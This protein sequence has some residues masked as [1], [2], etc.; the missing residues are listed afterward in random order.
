M[1][2]QY[3]FQKILDLK[4]DE[5]D[6]KEQEYSRSV[7]Q[8]EKV[9]TAL[10]QLLMQKEEIEAFY[11]ERIETGIKI[12]EIQHNE[13][14]L[15]QLQE[16]IYSEQNRA[17]IA[18]EKMLHKEK[19]MQAASVE[20]KKFEKLKEWKKEEHAKQLKKAEEQQLDEIT[21]RKYAFR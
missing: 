6:I 13:A 4:K 19:E 1:S 2:F 7:V 5:K 3:S 8:F 12:Q 10:Y 20:W 17:D 18:R 16:R 21:T 14:T 9:A 15:L 11:R